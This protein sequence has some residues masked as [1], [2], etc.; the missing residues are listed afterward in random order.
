MK[1]VSIVHMGLGARQGLY[2]SRLQHIQFWSTFVSLQSLHMVAAAAISRQHWGGAGAEE[3][4]R[5]T[6]NKFDAL[7]A[8]W[9][10]PY[11][12]CFIV[13]NCTLRSRMCGMHKPARYAQPY[14]TFGPRCRLSGESYVARPQRGLPTRLLGRHP[15]ISLHLKKWSSKT[16]LTIFTLESNTY[17]SYT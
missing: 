8:Q 15:H 16:S 10:H 9:R 11:C 17:S 5:I 6:D 2:F 14:G 7:V 3:K 13:I 4:K 1:R 12:I